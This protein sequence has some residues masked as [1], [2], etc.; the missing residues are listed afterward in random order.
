MSDT[1]NTLFE[2]LGKLEAQVLQII[3]EQDAKAKDHSALR[4]SIIGLVFA[5]LLQLIQYVLRA[6]K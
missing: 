4:A 3:K 1:S 2:R 5:L 6:H